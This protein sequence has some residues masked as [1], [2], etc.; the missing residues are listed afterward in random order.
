MKAKISAG[1]L[2][3]FIDIK[4]PYEELT[5]TLPV[6]QN[7]FNNSVEWN[8]VD[9][10]VFKLSHVASLDGEDIAI[11]NYHRPQLA[12]SISVFYQSQPYYNSLGEKLDKPYKHALPIYGSGSDGGPSNN[13]TPDGR[14]IYKTYTHSK[15]NNLIRIAREDN[16]K[17]LHP[18]QKPV[19]LLEYLIKTYTNEGETV[20]DFTM[21]SGS[22]GVACINTNRNFIGIE[23]DEKY[24]QIAKRRVEEATQ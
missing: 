18:T 16:R 22:T 2:S 17:S 7:V 14:R 11:Y 15:K 6:G 21:G 13:L 1:G 20:L 5:M 12:K 3:N 10:I 8:N 9:S 24:F 19:A 4:E 23:L